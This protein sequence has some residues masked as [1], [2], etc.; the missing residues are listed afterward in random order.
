M[1]RFAFIAVL[2]A[3]LL[4]PAMAHDYTVGALKIGHP[5]ARATPKGAAVG[6]GYITITNTG[7][8]PDRLV[9]GGT[10]IAGRFEVHEMSMDNGVMKM[11]MLPK[12]L[13][14]K[15]GETVTFKPGG[16][17]IMFTGLK[18]QLVQGERFK[19]TLQF[20]KAGTV[21]VDFAIEGIG[22]AKAGGAHGGHEMPGTKMKH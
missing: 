6:G 22:G 19:A 9:G 13:D 17:H 12:G 14:I 7:S 8:A 11:R 2:V 3:T 20:E 1:F 21:E 5:W 4:S 16:F 15:P 18:R 10:A